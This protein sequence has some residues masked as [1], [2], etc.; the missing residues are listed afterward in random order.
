MRPRFA[1]ETHWSYSIDL[2]QPLPN[3][4]LAWGALWER[5]DEVE[6]FR[7]REQRSTEWDR[8]NLDLY[9]ET[10]AIRGLVIRLTA[11]DILLPEEVRERRFFLPD[12]SLPSH[13][14]GIE[15]RRAI[16]GFGTRSYTLRISGRF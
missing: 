10:T 15:T 5:A 8:G 11:A 3:Q 1:G 12:R 4:N 16:G 13:L 9:V 7:V 6:V 14:S 2:R